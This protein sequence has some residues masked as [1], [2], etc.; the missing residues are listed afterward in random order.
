MASMPPMEWP[1]TIG[2]SAPMLAS[3]AWGVGRK[4]MQAE[5]ISLGFA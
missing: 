4:L 2:R 3:S 1:A 5:L